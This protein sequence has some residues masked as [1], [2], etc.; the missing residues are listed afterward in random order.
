MAKIVVV[1]DEQVLNKALS[2]ELLDA[3]YEVLSAA[4]GEAGL[5]LIQTEKPDL[6]LLDLVLPKMSGFEVLEAVK[7]DTKLKHIPVII[8][9]NLGQDEDREKGLKLGAEDYYVK[10]STDLSVISEKVSKLL[11]SGK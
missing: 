9:S 2:I 11:G 4:N 8:L 5:E 3:G 1:E 6:V 7:K 10:A